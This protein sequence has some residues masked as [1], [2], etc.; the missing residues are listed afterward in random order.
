M[1][2]STF[3]WTEDIAHPGVQVSSLTAS[4]SA[5]SAVLAI[6]IAWN[7]YT[8]ALPYILGTATVVQDPLTGGFLL[9]RQLPAKHPRFNWLR[10]T[11]ILNMQGRLG[12][13]AGLRSVPR[14]T[15]S[16]GLGITGEWADAVLTIMF[17]APPYQM[18]ED[19]D[20]DIEYQRWTTHN[21][22]PNLETL[23]RKGEEW[24]FPNAVAQ[25]RATSFAGDLLEKVPKGVL[26]WNWYDVPEDW[27]MSSRIFPTNLAGLVGKVNSTA[28]PSSLLLPPN[29]FTGRVTNFPAGTLL[30][31][32]PR[33]TPKTQMR[34]ERLLNKQQGNPLDFPRTFDV[35]LQMVYF[36]PPTDDTTRVT[37][38]GGIP[39]ANI[40]IRGHNLVPLKVPST[41]NRRWYAAMRTSTTSTPPVPVQSPV[42]D[43]AYLLYQY[44]DFDQ[45]FNLAT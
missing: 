25:A 28:W 22:S 17:E 27:I 3:A 9:S 10:A 32:P 11:R 37:N 29:I 15:N 7:D 12:G 4:S 21:F 38:A 31:M 2:Q 20:T 40:L 19:I 33:L 45:A 13:S 8:R 42:P 6:R 26:T 35:E 5:M 30:F 1:D 36:D 39:A 18:L 44:A 16:G 41:T 34:L 14:L 23:A 24:R 43:D